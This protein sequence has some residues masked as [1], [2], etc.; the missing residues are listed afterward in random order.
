MDPSHP[1]MVAA[2]QNPVKT[3]PHEYGV[4]YLEVMGGD[5]SPEL[6]AKA[7]KKK[8]LMEAQIA[9]AIVAAKQKYTDAEQSLISLVDDWEN[10][11]DTT[12][13]QRIALAIGKATKQLQEAETDLR[14]AQYPVRNI[15]QYD[16]VS[17]GLLHTGTGIKKA[18]QS[19]MYG[20][21]LQRT[22]LEDRIIA[23]DKA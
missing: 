6:R 8:E 10:T 5:A 23:T 2:I 13:K 4:D 16:R 15:K 3:I 7:E 21:Q 18:V 17:F 11:K 20:I 14:K 1:D 9:E 19:E 22:K 12:A